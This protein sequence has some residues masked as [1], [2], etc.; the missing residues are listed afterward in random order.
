MMVR[1]SMY[2]IGQSKL[3]ELRSTASAA[4]VGSVMC[5]G[6]PDG[7]YFV[8][9]VS[10][11]GRVAD[12]AR[13]LTTTDGVSLLCLPWSLASRCHARRQLRPARTSSPS[14]T[15]RDSPCDPVAVQ[16]ATLRSPAEPTAGD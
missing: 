16:I 8:R 2:T 13:R 7:M 6:L 15:G 12:D 5:L 11:R 10:G 9:R 1:T 3:A 14:A 4:R